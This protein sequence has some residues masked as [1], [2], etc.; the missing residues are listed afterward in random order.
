[1]TVNLNVKSGLARLMAAENITVI[2]SPKAKT[3]SFD[4]L[5]RVCRLPMLDDMGGHV[6]DA[7]IA[8]E[9]GHALYTPY[10]EAQYDAVMKEIPKVFLNIT[11]DARIEKMI[12]RKYPG[13]VKDFYKMYKQ[14]S[15]PES[16]FFGI[17]DKKL[18]NLTLI[19]RINL[20]FKI[21]AV[22]KIPFHK[23]ELPLVKLVSEEVTFEDAIEAAKKVYDFM[24]ANGTL[25]EITRKELKD[26]QAKNK[27]NKNEP[28]DGPESITV[29]K[30]G[31]KEKGEDNGE[32]SKD[33]KETEKQEGENEDGTEQSATDKGDSDGEQ[34]DSDSAMGQSDSTGEDAEDNQSEGN[35]D[36]EQQADGNEEGAGTDQTPEHDADGEVSGESKDGVNQTGGEVTPDAGATQGSFDKSMSTKFLGNK[37]GN[38]HTQHFGDIARHDDTWKNYIK[39]LAVPH[40]VSVDAY[41]RYIKSISPTV[42]MMVSYFNMK[43]SAKDYTRSQT[44]KSGEL[45][46]DQL[47][48]YKLSEDIFLRNEISFDSQNHGMLMMVDWS[49][50]MSTY[51]KYTI[52]QLIVLTEFCRKAQIPF[53]VYGFTSGKNHFTSKNS[54]QPNTIEAN[55]DVRI[56]KMFSSS[57]S[58]QRYKTL[59]AHIYNNTV[60]ALK[61]YS[62]H[63]M[64]STPI[65]SMAFLSEYMINDFKKRFNRDKTIFV[66]L[67]DGE[68]TD[69]LYSDSKMVHPNHP[70]TIMVMRDSQTGKNYTYNGKID[71]GLFHTVFKY[72]KEKTGVSKMMGFFVTNGIKSNT[73]RTVSPR[74]QYSVMVTE[75]ERQFKSDKFVEFGKD[76]AFDKYFVISIANF[77]VNLDQ[78]PDLDINQ[79]STPKQKQKA[80]ST[81]LEARTK[82]LIFMRT[83]T[84]E[85]S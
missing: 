30:D 20:H 7:F 62:V 82:P 14:F 3:A 65:S 33:N 71:G 9:I 78:A 22:M 31:K 45:D 80:I 26:A 24:K 10:N 66:M 74:R 76:V 36:G 69:Y 54:A 84:E 16:D 18:E 57:D 39:E 4:I 32:D 81:F 51:L 13:T 35:G 23:T 37:K 40:G 68:E 21:G 83:F 77:D 85:I 2:H 52:K 8:H 53:E 5:N 1:M 47:S 67:S 42:N 11:E 38:E 28:K 15:T 59:S 19:D 61:P 73:V 46:V 29:L 70:D 58:N 43:K 55:M 41:N 25:V 34:G 64:Q 12:K 44:T 6:Y 56:F 49:S 27:K 60:D 48:N 75:V 50:S 72:V 17:K 63:D 79:W